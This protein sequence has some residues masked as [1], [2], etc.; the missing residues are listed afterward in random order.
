MNAQQ[1]L[2]QVEQVQDPLGTGSDETDLKAER[3]QESFAARLETAGLKAERVQEL[4]Q[5]LPG[6]KLTAGG[7]SIDRMRVFTDPGVAEAYAT[8]V[9]RLARSKGQAVAIDHAASHV[10]V[11]IYGQVHEVCIGALNEETFDLAADIG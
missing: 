10:I 8:Y 2:S 11:T 1:K 6:W 3:V 5:S 9:S 7:Q 4:L